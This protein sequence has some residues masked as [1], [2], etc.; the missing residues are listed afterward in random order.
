[1]QV[2]CPG[3][4]VVDFN[5][6]V[7]V[8]SDGTGVDIANV[9]MSMNPFDE[10]A[11]EEAVRL[12]EKGVVT[13]II[14]VSCGVTQCQETLRTAMAIGADRAI[15]VETPADLEP[16][17]VAKLLKALVD[18]EQPGL[19]ILGKQAIDDDCNQTGQM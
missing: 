7:R 19:V 13:E 17:A 6:K 3:K 1:M 12:K 11:V 16:L 8:K 14:A 15:L 18:K 9:K 5:V 10:I 4:R 2:L